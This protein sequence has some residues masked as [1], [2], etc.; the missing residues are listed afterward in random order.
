MVITKIEW[1]IAVANSNS[2]RGVARYLGIRYRSDL[3]KAILGDIPDI[4]FSHFTGGK[5]YKSL[6]GRKFNKLSILSLTEEKKRT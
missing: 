5:K 6:V 1:K 4:D 3:K 2:W